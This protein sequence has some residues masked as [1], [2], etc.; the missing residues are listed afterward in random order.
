MVFACSWTL[1][2][3]PND[4][5]AAIRKAAEKLFSPLD[6]DDPSATTKRMCLSLG[7]SLVLQITMAIATAAMLWANPDAGSTRPAFVHP[8]WAWLVRPMPA[9]AVAIMAVISPAEYMENVVEIQVVE[10]LIG[11]LAVGLYGSVMLKTFSSFDGTRYTDLASNSPAYQ[12]LQRLQAG[13]VFGFIT[14][15]I[16]WI[17]LLITLLYRAIPELM[18]QLRGPRR[19]GR[20]RHIPSTDKARTRALIKVV[21]VLFNI[22]KLIA[23]FLIWG[24]T[25]ALDP[26]VFCPKKETITGITVLWAFVP[27]VDQLWRACFSGW[28]MREKDD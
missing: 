23:G 17:I 6:E 5:R 20:R 27:A 14:W 3:G 2:A 15:I 9:T 12:A 16:T 13:T 24:G 11:L 7:G 4:I 22:A 21:V 10:V 18:H 1:I 25:L 8:L 26:D 28:M 19:A